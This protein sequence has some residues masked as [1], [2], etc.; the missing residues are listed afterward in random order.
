M[1]YDRAR[2]F[3]KGGDGGNGCVAMR[4]EKYVPEGGPWGGDGGRGGNV[5]LRADGG[6][7]TLVDFRYKRHY[8]AERGRH[9]EG[10][11][12][13]GA[14]GEDLVIRVPA[15]TV[16]KDAATGELIADLV[17]DGQEAVVARGGRGGR[18]NARFVTPQNRAPRMAEKGEPG[19]ERWLD[20]ELKL[21]ADVGLVGFPNAGKSTLI[22]RVSAARPKIASYPFTTI[23]PNLGVVRVDDGR[24]FVMAD[25]PGLI[26]GAHKGAG[27]GHDFL[28]H[29]ERTR[30]LVHVLDTAGSEGRD[31]VQDFLVTN[32]ELSLYNPALGRRPQVIA[33][34]KM[35]LD[36]AAENLARLKEAYGGKYEIFPVSA[37]TGQGLEA[38]VYR[39]SALLE[40]I[41]A[42]AAV[43]EAL[44]RPVIHQAGPRFT[45]CR[46]E[47]V[48]LVGGKEI[49]RHVV[50]TDLK[51]EEAVERL[52]RI[53]RRMGIE[54][55][56]KEAGIKDGDTVRIGDY[57]F[58]YV[59]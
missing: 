29:V 45:V 59:E 15:G 23:T 33:A 57:E 50:M 18:G 32:R 17:R 44:E 54:E 38:L 3:V 37:V 13:H 16:V 26:E 39:V 22:S 6:L 34:N 52:Q 53:I 30:L 25:I 14:S 5:I 40:E 2:I 21:L 24:S 55:A 41:P 28:R 43:P 48:F 36:G 4:R 51:N 46:E 58:E 11:N 35:D 47:G 56:L 27:L 10:K 31:P 19:E 1:F 7:R 9:G 49:E 12:M 20:L 8:K 42:G